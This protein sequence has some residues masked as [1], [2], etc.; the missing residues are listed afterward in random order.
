MVYR[1]RRISA[2]PIFLKDGL[3]LGKGEEEEVNS[4]GPND[5]RYLPCSCKSEQQIIKFYWHSKGWGRSVPFPDMLIIILTM[6][7]GPGSY[8][9]FLDS[10]FFLLIILNYLFFYIINY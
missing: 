4:C 5:Y 7:S 9:Y 6:R 3:L 10:D 1:K 2:V 8:T